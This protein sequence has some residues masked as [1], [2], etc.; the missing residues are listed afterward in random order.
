MKCARDTTDIPGESLISFGA[1]WCD[2]RGLNAGS[3]VLANCLITLMGWECLLPS[4]NC[5]VVRNSLANS[6]H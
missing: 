3:V 4:V 5:G 2:E 1:A 6:E